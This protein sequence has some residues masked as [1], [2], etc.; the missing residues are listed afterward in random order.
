MHKLGGQSPSEVVKLMKLDNGIQLQ[1]LDVTE[2][3]V[4]ERNAAA[5]EL[6]KQA[7]ELVR[8]CA[9]YLRPV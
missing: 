3:L 9:D 7:A 4:N 6:T 8:Y 5:N 2:Q 1:E